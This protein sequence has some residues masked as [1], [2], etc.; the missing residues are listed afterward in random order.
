MYKLELKKIKK[1]YNKVVALNDVNIKV[2]DGEFISILGPSGCGKS[3][4][5]KIIAGLERETEGEIFI[6][7]KRVNNLSPKDR[8]IAMVFQNYALYP[9]MRVFDNIAIGLKLRGYNK[10]FIKKKVKSIV[11]L[12]GIEN[13]LD[14]FPKQLSGGQQQRVALARAIVREPEIFLLDEPLSNLDAQ[15]REQTRIELKKL[16]RSLNAT[17][18]YVTHD[19]IEAITMSDRIIVMRNGKVQQIGKPEDIYHMPQNIFVARFVGTYRINIIDGYIENGIFKNERISIPIMTDYSGKAYIGIRPE[20]IEIGKGNFEAEIKLVEPLG[21]ENIYYA[22]LNGIEIK[23]VSKE[24]F[25]TGKKVKLHIPTDKVYVFDS[26]GK[27]I[28]QQ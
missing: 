14:R 24:K 22:D 13:L 9:H 26:E 3:T 12:L 1:I 7:G 10:E 11:K 17:V 20:F 28:T 25:P 15:I 8:N 4:L 16:F 6:S 21:A 23:F 2:K 5:L 19:Q 18:L 27:N